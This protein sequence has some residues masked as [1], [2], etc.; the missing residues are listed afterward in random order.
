[1]PFWV[2]ECGTGNSE[3][4]TNPRNIR[5]LSPN[6]KGGGDIRLNLLCKAIDWGIN[7]RH[8]KHVSEGLVSKN[9][10]LVSKICNTNK[11][12]KQNFFI[13]KSS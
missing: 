10:Q 3:T 13:A 12:A 1:M 2:V 11:R 7:L 5:L 6:F 9:L 4:H 8:I